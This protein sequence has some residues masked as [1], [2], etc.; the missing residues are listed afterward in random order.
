MRVRATVGVLLLAGLLA[1]ACG[2]ERTEPVGLR[3][4]APSYVTHEGQRIP[5]VDPTDDGIRL[6]DWAFSRYRAGGLAE[7]I[8]S[9]IHFG[10]DAP[11]CEQVSGWTK[12][13]DDVEIAICIAPDRL[14]L[15]GSDGELATWSKLCVLHE[16]AHA[17][18][19]VN[20]GAETEAVFLDHVGLEQWLTTEDTPWHE[21]GVEYAAEVVAWGLMET[22]LPII[23][24][25]GPPC[26]HLRLAYMTLTGNEPLVT[27]QG[28]PDPLGGQP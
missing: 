3:S 8:V 2:A 28:R 1:G 25:G 16:L 17:W 13:L 9:T 27:C 20:V 4:D 19:A 14:C 21:R 10:P 15:P 24:L 7:P 26:E 23:R 12:I 11:G 18:L 22:R 6:L 5:L